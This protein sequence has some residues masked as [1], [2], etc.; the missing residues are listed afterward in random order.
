MKNFIVLVILCCGYMTHAQT[1]FLHTAR[2]GQN[3]TNNWTTIDNA[4]T[5][6]NP[7]AVLIVTSNWS[8]TGPYHNKAIG[9]WY[10]GGK[11]TIFNQDRSAMTDKAMFNVMVLQPS[12]GAF[13]ITGSAISGHIATLDHPSLN[14]NPNAKFLATQNWGSSGPYNNNPTGIWYNG[15]KWTIY[16]QNY[17]AMPANAKFNVVIDSR[18][19]QVEAPATTSNNWFTFDH[20]ATNGDPNKL[21][22]ASQYWTSV[23]N[24]HEIGVWYTG[25]KWSVYN[26]DLAKMPANAK[27]FVMSVAPTQSEKAFL[28]TARTGQNISNNWTTID[29]PA[30]NNKSDA[31]LIVTS[32]W[33]TTG[34]YHNKSIGVWYTGGKW[35]IF[36]QDKSA[37]TDNAMFN[38]M[39][40][41]PSSTAFV[42]TGS[43]ISGHVAVLDHPSLNNNPNIKFLI[44]QNWGSS[45]PYNNNPI[46]IWYNGSKWTVYNQNYAAMPPGAK[47]NIVI[48]SR[49]FQ[50]EAPATTSNNWFTFDN[51]A[52]NGNPDKLVFASQYWTSVYNPHEIGVWYTSNKWSVYNQDLV[53]MPANA[54]F[55]ILGLNAN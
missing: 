19:F 10:T 11:W 23:Y 15:S 38:V 20:G 33:R 13:V 51:T 12:S 37:M 39:A 5:N 3:I 6:N 41:P 31:V 27:F 50:V 25:G 29:N 35:T 17:A 40:V 45:G 8:T 21:V 14:N 1:A 53:K 16:N 49:I 24:P 36:N 32:N 42:V 2:A 52:T 30:T 46:G 9:V 44:T 18:I 7:N 54:K 22:F 55:F 43:A 48:D 26:Q 47:F 34:P 4:A 28:H